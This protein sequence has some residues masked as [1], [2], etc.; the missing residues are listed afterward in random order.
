MTTKPN[1]SVD[2]Y[3]KFLSPTLLMTTAPSPFNSSCSELN[4]EPNFAKIRCHLTEIRSVACKWVTRTQS[5]SC[6]MTTAPPQSPFNSSCSELQYEPNFAKIQCH[7]TEIRSF[8]CKWLART[9]TDSRLMTIRSNRAAAAIQFILLWVLKW[10]DLVGGP[11]VQ[12]I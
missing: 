5:D 4:Y 11:V 10:A 1:N 2:I 12:H 8:A 3:A 7:L 9:H 6:L